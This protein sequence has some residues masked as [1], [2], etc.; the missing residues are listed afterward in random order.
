MFEPLIFSS[1]LSLIDPENTLV[2][3]QRKIRASFAEIS[4]SD[5]LYNNAADIEAQY[6]HFGF[7]TKRTIP[8]FSYYTLLLI[9]PGKNNYLGD[10]SDQAL[11]DFCMKQADG[12]YYIYNKPLCNFVKIDASNRDSRDFWHWIRALSLVSQ[13]N[14]W[15]KYEKRYVDWIMEQRNKDGLWE[16]PK[17]F[18][19]ALSDSWRGKNKII[20]ST[21][22][23]LRLLA[24]KKTF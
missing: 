22:F 12:I 18:D 5:G 15:D 21:I 1:M 13:F 10:N 20:D 17:K 23:V 6:A 7:T 19:F 8:P 4:F 14:G 3:E 9:A 2:S 24:K 16:F 11:V